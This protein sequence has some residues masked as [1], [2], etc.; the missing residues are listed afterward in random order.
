MSGKVGKWAGQ[1]RN[2]ND[3]KWWAE[4]AAP[5]LCLSRYDIFHILSNYSYS[6]FH[7]GLLETIMLLSII[8]PE[9]S[10]FW[11]HSNRIGHSAL[12]HLLVLS[13]A[14]LPILSGGGLPGGGGWAQH[15]LRLPVWYAVVGAMLL[16]S[17][18]ECCEEDTPGTY[19]MLQS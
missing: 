1:R 12:C 6:S 4:E 16:G 10:R 17:E 7:W 11:E 9:N 13:W 2:K 14:T 15:G 19:S 5:L 18:L 3:N 8:H